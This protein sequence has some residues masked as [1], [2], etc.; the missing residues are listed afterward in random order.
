MYFFPKRGKILRYICSSNLSKINQNSQ[1]N[2]NIDAIKDKPSS[3]VT[4]HH[5]RYTLC[6]NCNAEIMYLILVA[7]S[8]TKRHTMFISFCTNKME[9]HSLM[10]F[11][12]D[13][14]YKCCLTWKDAHMCKNWGDYNMDL[15]I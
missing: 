3:L 2:P 4:G 14:I 15:A 1:I 13:S 9:N 7:T 10:N 8:F 12:V 5:I 6:E 11:F